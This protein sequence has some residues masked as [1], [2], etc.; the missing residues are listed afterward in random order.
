MSVRA[1]VRGRV[2]IN[3]PSASLPGCVREGCAP[4]RACVRTYEGT[5]LRTTG[6]LDSAPPHPVEGQLS[7]APG[8]RCPG[9]GGSVDGAEAATTRAGRSVLSPRSASSP[10]LGVGGGG[11]GAGTLTRPRG[12]G[13]LSC[14]VA[15]AWSAE[16]ALHSLGGTRPARPKE[17]GTR[18]AHASSS[19]LRA[20][21]YLWAGVSRTLCL[22]APA[23]RR[24]PPFSAPAPTPPPSRARHPSTAVEQR[25]SSVPRIASVHVHAHRCAVL[26]VL[27]A[28]RMALGLWPQKRP[29]AMRCSAGCP[30]H[31]SR[32]GTPRMML[33]GTVLFV[34]SP[35][36]GPM[37]SVGGLDSFLLLDSG[38]AGL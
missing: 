10:C 35:N 24:R 27:S 1:R 14:N 22:G 13:G 3:C 11:P 6:A 37:D 20:Q 30:W 32:L 2:T 8:A 17:V 16:R 33:R 9:G 36:P 18:Q 21:G 38:S 34:G 26:P 28:S 29:L 31:P 5:S 19:A 7:A 25:R 4:A 23:E 15:A 12:G